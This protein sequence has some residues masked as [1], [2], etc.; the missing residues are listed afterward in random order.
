[1]NR[2]LNIEK[3]LEELAQVD[4]EI[5]DDVSPISKILA[6]SNVLEFSVTELASLH[7]KNSD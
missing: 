6:K 7:R 2:K 1:V 3:K 4:D 5:L